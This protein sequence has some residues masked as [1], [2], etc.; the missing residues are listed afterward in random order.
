MA[1]QAGLVATL[2]VTISLLALLVL[3]C[4]SKAKKEA[5]KAADPDEGQPLPCVFP[6]V[7]RVHCLVD[8]SVGFLRIALLLSVSKR[9]FRR[10]A[11][12]VFTTVVGRQ[13]RPPV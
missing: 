4:V 3:G 7:T 11:D 8:Q 1:Q 5:K 12:S 10:K 13:V 9:H 6:T 2:L